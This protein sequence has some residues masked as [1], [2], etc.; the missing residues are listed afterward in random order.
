MESL[1]QVMDMD[2]VRLG[3]RCTEIG[4]HV[5]PVSH[6]PNT[7]VWRGSY[8]CVTMAVYTA[9]ELGWYHCNDWKDMPCL[10]LYAPVQKVCCL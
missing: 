1:K 4:E 10:S 2:M 3:G 8:L 9:V 7:T 5:A 6:P